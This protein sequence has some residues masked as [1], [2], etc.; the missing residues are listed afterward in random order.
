MSKV[1]VIESL[2]LDVLF[3]DQVSA[4]WQLPNKSDVIVIDEVDYDIVEIYH[5]LKE[6]G[7]TIYVNEGDA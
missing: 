4:T 7:I 6:D 2:S 5:M 1:T 3:E